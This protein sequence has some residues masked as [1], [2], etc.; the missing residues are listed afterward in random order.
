MLIK[1][2]IDVMKTINGCSDKIKLALTV[3]MQ[4]FRYLIFKN[5]RSLVEFTNT[6]K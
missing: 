5:A 6:L 2:L 1:Q 3:Q 4:D